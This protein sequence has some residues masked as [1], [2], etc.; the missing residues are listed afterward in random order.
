[1]DI[2][3]ENDS[4][5]RRWTAYDEGNR[6]AFKG[7]LLSSNPYNEV[8]QHLYWYNGHRDGILT[9]RRKWLIISCVFNAIFLACIVHF[10]VR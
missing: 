10:L 1:M 6:A 3:L 4:W 5:G 7:E 9:L 8:I 2:D